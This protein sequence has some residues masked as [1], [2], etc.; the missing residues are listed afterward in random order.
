[1]A[2]FKNSRYTMTPVFVSRGSA[3]L[4]TRQRCNF[5]LENSSYYTVIEGDTIDG[6]AFKQ[7]G[8]ASLF[9][10]IIDANPSYMTEL[11]IKPGDIIVIPDF[12]EVLQYV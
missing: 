2:V 3:F 6:I 7:Y 9:W 5:N 12:S 4:E 1:M 8:N 11:D 10:A